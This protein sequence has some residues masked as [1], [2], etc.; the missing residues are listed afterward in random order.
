MAY[1]TS[2]CLLGIPGGCVKYAPSYRIIFFRWKCCSVLVRLNFEE[3]SF[4]FVDLICFLFEIV[5]E[6]NA[7]YS[8]RPFGC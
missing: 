3:L 6:R 5:G 7:F 8:F 4:Q 1:P 2:L